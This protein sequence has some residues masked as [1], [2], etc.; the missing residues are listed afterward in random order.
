MTAKAEIESLAA[1]TLALTAILTKVLS[2]LRQL[3]PALDGAIG[4]ALDDAA[5]TVEDNA[6]RLGKSASPE[7]TVKAILI[8]EKMRE[9]LGHH[10]KPKGV[11]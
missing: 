9:A 2:Q 3:S 10:S 7:H 11:V 1:E 5:C 8:V 6:I 4:R